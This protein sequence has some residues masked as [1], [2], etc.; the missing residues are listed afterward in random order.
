MGELPG[1]GP[2]VLGQGHHQPANFGILLSIFEAHPFGELT[3]GE[4][5]PGG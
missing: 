5:Q 3:P 4:G 1:P 2:Q